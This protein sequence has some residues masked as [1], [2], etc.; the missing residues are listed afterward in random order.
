VPTALRGHSGTSGHW[1]AVAVDSL[2]LIG[3]ALWIGALLH[4]VLAL[5]RSTDR[6]AA[7][8]AAARRYSR[9]ALPTVAVILVSG[10]LTALAEF[11]SLGQL[12]D[13]GYGR[14]L[15][16]KS[17]LAGAALLFAYSARRWALAR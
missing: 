7:L 3:A 14:T 15:L 5:A 17:A 4:L 2:H 6:G 11:R 8:A 12:V 16:I 13:T 10:V 9:L 1:W